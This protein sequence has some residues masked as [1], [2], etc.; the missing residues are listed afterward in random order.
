M[1]DDYPDSITYEN[2]NT[3]HREPKTWL[4]GLKKP[5]TTEQVSA[6]LQPHGFFL[7]YSN[8]RNKIN[9]TKTRFWI[10]TLEEWPDIDITDLTGTLRRV[11]GSDYDWL[12][13]AYANPQSTRRARNYLSATTCISNHI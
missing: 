3:I 5:Y 9:N 12:G 13:L 10:S 8:F 4:L 6:K 11:F 7:K 1:S 2:G